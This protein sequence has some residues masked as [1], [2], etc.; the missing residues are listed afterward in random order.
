MRHD[1][2]PCVVWHDS[3]PWVMPTCDMP[4][5]Q[6]CLRVTWLISVCDLT[7]SYVCALLCFINLILRFVTV[8][9]YPPERAKGHAPTI[10]NFRRTSWPYLSLGKLRWLDRD[11]HPPPK[12][13]R[14][15]HWFTPL[16]LSN[17]PTSH[18]D[19]THSVYWHDSFRVLSHN[20]T[21][22]VYYH[23]IWLIP[24]TITWYYSSSSPCTDMTHSVYWHDSFR[25]L[26]HDIMTGIRHALLAQLYPST[27]TSVNR[28]S[29]WRKARLDYWYQD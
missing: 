21:N 19:M 12:P 10:E 16:P 3:F 11:P 26:S 14:W 13:R 17:R 20:I 18:G 23:I 9:G 27:R 8:P 1:V 29:S 25:I 7:H 22:S 4:S 5:H 6:S 15:L 28:S 2:F 24:Y